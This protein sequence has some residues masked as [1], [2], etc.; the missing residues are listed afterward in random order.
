MDEKTDIYLAENAITICEIENEQ[1]KINNKEFIEDIFESHEFA[2]K[3]CC[4]HPYPLHNFD[5]IV[6]KVNS[7]QIDSKDKKLLLFRLQRIFTKVTCL[8]KIYKYS[9]FYSRVFIVIASILAP[10]LTSINTDEQN[11][12]YIY[13]WWIIWNLQICISL[14]TSVSTFFKWDRNYFL[15]SEFKDKIEEEVWHFLQSTHDYNHKDL[16]TKKSKIINTKNLPDFSQKIEEMYSNLCLKDAEIKL[17]NLQFNKNDSKQNIDS[18][19]D[20]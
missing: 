19:S 11:P 13:L 5:I 4:Y 3:R 12:M 1:N 20:N 17:S 9:Y 8:Q 6:D 14:L 10:T 16:S 2:V 7:L 15:Y 18:E